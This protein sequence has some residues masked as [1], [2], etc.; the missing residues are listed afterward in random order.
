MVQ[1]L[2][3]YMTTNHNFDWTDL[4]QQSIAPVF[5]FNVFIIIIIIIIILILFYF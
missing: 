5:F 3:P 2:Q 4:C 1:L